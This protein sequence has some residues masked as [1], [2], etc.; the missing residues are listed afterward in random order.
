MVHTILP[1]TQE[2]EAGIAGAQELEASLGNI[3]KSSV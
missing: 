3:E 2:D 1:S